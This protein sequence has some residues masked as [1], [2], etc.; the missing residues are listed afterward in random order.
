M[1]YEIKETV[2]LTYTIAANTEKEAIQM[3]KD[4]VG[5]SRPSREV[6]KMT[7][8]QQRPSL[9]LVHNKKEE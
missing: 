3:W 5:A 6:L 2:Q 8:K 7:C 9:K 4:L 1:M